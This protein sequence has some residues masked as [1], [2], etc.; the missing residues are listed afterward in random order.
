M[1]YAPG[2][3]ALVHWLLPPGGEAIDAVAALE[4]LDPGARAPAGRPHLALNMVGSL[5]GV[6][7]VAGRSA[8]LSSE[9]DRALFHGLRGCFDAVMMGASTARIERYGPIVPDAPAQPIAV[10]ASASLA[11]DPDLPLLADPASRIVMLTPSAG[12][13]APCAADVSYVRGG[14]FAEMLAALRE[15]HGVRSVLCEGGPRLNRMLLGEGV[16]DELFLSLAPVL[17]GEE[18]L[19]IVAGA[20]LRDVELDLLWLLESGSHLHA[21]YAVVSRVSSATT[22][23]SSLAS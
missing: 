6:A 23:S 22:S 13:L 2:V 5:D 15:Q 18:S 3:S 1:Y 11:L 10:I 4:G 20:L 14:S 8:G 7:T 19:H 17:R 16:V 12:E 9:A 21:R